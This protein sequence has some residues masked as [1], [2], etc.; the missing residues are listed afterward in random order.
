MTFCNIRSY[1]NI[2]KLYIIISYSFRKMREQQY[3]SRELLY[4][5]Y[6]LISYYFQNSL[7]IIFNLLMLFNSSFM[8]HPIELRRYKL[9]ETFHLYSN[10]LVSKHHSLQIKTSPKLKFKIGFWR[11]SKFLRCCRYVI[12]IHFCSITS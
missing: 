11:I 4:N 5:K 8:L 9:F 10:S 3:P 6:I 7:F 1:K 2:H 12:V